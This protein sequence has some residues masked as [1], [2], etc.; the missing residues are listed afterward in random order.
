MIQSD[1]DYANEG[2]NK[3]VREMKESLKKAI[4]ANAKEN[5]K[6][7]D[8]ATEILIDNEHLSFDE[9]SRVMASRTGK[10]VGS[11][12]ISKIRDDLGL[13]PRQGRRDDVT[14]SVGRSEFK[15]LMGTV[16]VK[17]DR[18]APRL[19]NSGQRR[20]ELATQVIGEHPNLTRSEICAVMR[21]KGEL[22]IDGSMVHKI[23]C[24]LG[25]PNPT[26]PRTRSARKAAR[27]VIADYRKEAASPPPRAEPVSPARA[28]AVPTA[29]L[30]APGAGPEAMVRGAIDVITRAIPGLAQMTI[31]VDADG[32]SRCSYEVRVAQMTFKA[33]G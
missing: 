26:G 15:A 30:I 4:E 17:K 27:K 22:G 3:M 21:I 12:I 8:I 7:I 25:I 28:N 9:L 29:I 2:N 13:P 18:L 16:A 10:G 20:V 32:A 11:S 33:G 14:A 19:T 6:R 5:Q 1:S 31:T 24:D 23:K